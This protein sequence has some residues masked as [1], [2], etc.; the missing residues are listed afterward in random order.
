MLRGLGHFLAPP[1]RCH[2]SDNLLPK[3]GVKKVNE[4]ME[5]RIIRKN[6]HLNLQKRHE[7]LTT[8]SQIAIFCSNKKQTG[9]RKNTYTGQC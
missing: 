3:E 1:K 7:N 5:E 2:F 6:L 9:E 4:K 8:Y